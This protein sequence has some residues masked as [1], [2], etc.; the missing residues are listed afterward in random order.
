MLKI[1]CNGDVS[2]TINNRKPN[3]TDF[4]IFIKRNSA[5]LTFFIISSCFVISTANEI[6]C[7]DDDV[8]DE[9]SCFVT[10]TAI[11]A[12]DFTISGPEDDTVHSF[13]S[14]YNR[15]VEFLPIRIGKK[16]PN[17]VKY[18]ADRCRIGDISKSNFENL[19]HLRTLNLNGNKLEIIKS[20]SF[21]DLVSLESLFLGNYTSS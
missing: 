11:N 7:E 14:S 4:Q 21:K 20:D 13:I 8:N 2:T 18:A 3:L 5:L 16:F 17:L 1:K 15:N 9:P 19:F 12:S 10:E 6:T